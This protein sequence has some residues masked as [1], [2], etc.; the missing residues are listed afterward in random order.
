[1]KLSSIIVHTV[2]GTAPPKSKERE[3]SDTELSAQVRPRHVR[4]VR[5]QVI[6]PAK[7]GFG[8]QSPLE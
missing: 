5:D 6:A 8:S 1:M 4:W 3:D 2:D 7:V